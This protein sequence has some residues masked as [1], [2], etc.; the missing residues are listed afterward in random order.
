MAGPR[1]TD[2]TPNLNIEA[3]ELDLGS[4]HSFRRE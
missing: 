2:L 4:S 1:D 3:V